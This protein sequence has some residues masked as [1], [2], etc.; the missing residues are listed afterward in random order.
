MCAY[1][2]ELPT[3]ETIG[4]NLNHRSRHGRALVYDAFRARGKLTIDE[5]RIVVW[6]DGEAR[7][8]STIYVFISR[9]DRVLKKHGIAILRG[10]GK[11]SST[12][13]LGPA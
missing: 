10:I 3:A 7:D 5:I 2:D 13:R 6:P 8:H 12:Y 4:F 1:C 9:M 11:D